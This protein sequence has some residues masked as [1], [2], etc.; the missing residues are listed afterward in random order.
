MR[1]EYAPRYDFKRN[2][3]W[4]AYYSPHGNHAL[5]YR[6]TKYGGGYRPDSTA[7]ELFWKVRHCNIAFGDD[8]AMMSEIAFDSSGRISAYPL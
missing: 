3:S 7:V 1:V 6:Y 2:S 8:V 5:A 4:N